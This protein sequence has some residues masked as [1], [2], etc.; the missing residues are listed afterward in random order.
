MPIAAIGN[1]LAMPH[2]INKREGDIMAN[3]SLTTALVAGA[4]L[5]SCFAPACAQSNVTLYGVADASITSSSSGAAGAHRVNGVSSGVGSGS[6]IGFRGAE[7]LGGGLQALFQLEM[8]FDLD[9]GA[10]KNFVGDYSSATP[11]APGGVSSSGGFNRRS[12]VG[13][14]SASWGTLLLGRE[15]TPTYYTM[16]AT[17]TFKLAYLGNVQSLIGLTGGS[18][19]FARSSNGIFYTSPSFSGLQARAMYGFGSESA[20]GAG[21]PPE[22]ANKFY[23]VGADYKYG[24]LLLSASYQNIKLPTTGG[25]PLAFTG[26]RTREDIALG[27]QYTLGPV[28]FSAG[29]FRVNAPLHGNDTWLGA[30]YTFDANAVKVQVQRLRQENLAGQERKAIMLGVAFE[31][32]LSKRTT[33]YAS[34][35]RAK[36]NSTGQFGLYGGDFSLAA[37]SAGADPNVIAL[38][39]RH[40][41]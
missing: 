14:Q 22:D 9:T 38:G 26:V 35:S 37:G 20:G 28:S 41:F 29:Y 16:L 40:V 31:H 17:D 30:G 11:S 12:V 10:L 24:N 39:M 8:G 33:L 13:L 3:K 7:D 5:L 1:V 34:Y 19:R 36:N 32:Y 25:A 21:R 27:A 4:A 6:R 18:E 23:G 15:Y 2:G